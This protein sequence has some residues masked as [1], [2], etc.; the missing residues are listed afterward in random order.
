M[1]HPVEDIV[2]YSSGKGKKTYEQLQEEGGGG[3]DDTDD[4]GAGK[5]RAYCYCSTAVLLIGS[6]ATAVL[7]TG[8]A[9]T[10]ELLTGSAAPGFVLKNRKH[11]NETRMSSISL[12]LYILKL[13]K[14]RIDAKNERRTCF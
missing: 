5:V 9:A 13:Y 6:A 2:Y 3:D 1:T 8:S 10:A 4:D 11:Q 14:P 12:F 7:L